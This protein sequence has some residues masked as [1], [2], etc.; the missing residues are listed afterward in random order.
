M[1]AGRQTSD[2]NVKYN[3]AGTNVLGKVNIILRRTEGQVL[4]T[5]QITSNAIDTL[6]INTLAG[7]RYRATFTSKANLTDITDPLN[8]VPVSSV[9]NGLLQI[10]LAD[11]GEPG[12][13][14]TIGITYYNKDGGLVFS[15][16]WSKGRTTEQGLKGGSLQVRPAQLLDGADNAGA[17]L[18]VTIT[19]ADA[20]GMLPVALARWEAAGAEANLLRSLES[21]RIQVDDFSSGD[22]AWAMPGVITIDCDASGYGWFVDPT[23]FDNAEFADGVAL[24]RLRDEW[25]S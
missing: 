17:P 14:D 10:T 11:N 18:G 15:N 5:Y 13:R 7:P 12:S 6:T 9:G 23:P 4:R 3:K 8:P 1:S 16:Q 24:A 21:V 2:F 19:T 25:T 22:L 20:Q